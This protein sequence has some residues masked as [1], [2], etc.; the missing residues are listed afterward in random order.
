MIKGVLI[1]LA[2]VVYQ[3]DRILPG[4]VDAIAAL[5]DAHLP[6][7]F[8]TNT[9]RKSLHTVT[10]QLSAFGI[11]IET[12]QVF[13]PAMAAVGWLDKHGYSPHL[14][15]HPDLEEDF[16][17]CPRDR[18]KALVVGDAGPLFTYERLN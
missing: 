6:Y 14:L 13:T 3:G 5:T 1:D 11:P 7:R 9:T 2:G 16:A 4:A 17:Q 15:I 8:L 12:S 10:E 18:P